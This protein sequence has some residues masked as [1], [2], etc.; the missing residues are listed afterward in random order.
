MSVEGGE[1]ERPKRRRRSPDEARS[2]A[3]FSARQL[4]IARGPD[5]LTLKNVGDEIGMTHANLIHHFGS[6]AGLQAALMG[7]MVRDLAQALDAA[8][9][10]VRSDAAAPRILVDQV[11][12]AFEQGG[13]GRLA[14]WIALTGDLSQLEPI[15]SAVQDLVAAIHE[16]F[17]DE[18]EEGRQRINSAV[19]FIALCAFGDAMIGGP[20]RDMLGRD[21]EAS[22]KIVARL[23]PTFFV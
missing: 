5:A 17:A 8:V 1:A 6:A 16:S 15:R 12:D 9:V 21:G 7:S 3:V 14:A 10:H 23:L 20:L 19:L 22:R 4:L 18:G 2:E 11:F 13:A